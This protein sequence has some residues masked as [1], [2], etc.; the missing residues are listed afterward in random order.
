MTPRAYATPSWFAKKVGGFDRPVLAALVFS[1]LPLLPANRNHLAAEPPAPSQHCPGEVR[2]AV[3]GIGTSLDTSGGPLGLV[4]VLGAGLTTPIDRARLGTVNLLGGSGGPVGPLA[5]FAY[6]SAGEQGE[7]WH[8]MNTDQVSPIPDSLRQLVKDGTPVASTEPE[9]QAYWNTVARAGHTSVDAFRAAAITNWKQCSI[10][11]DRKTVRGEVFYLEGTLKNVT[12]RAVPPSGQ[13]ELVPDLYTAEMYDNAEP[14]NVSVIHFTDLPP[15]VRFEKGTAL[16]VSFA[17]YF[18]KLFPAGPK[19]KLVPLFIGRMVQPLFSTDDG[20]P[21]ATAALL[22]ACQAGPSE[23]TAALTALAL[24]RTNEH[25]DYW[26]LY[27]P[28]QLPA[29]R[30]DLLLQVHDRRFFPTIGGDD[31]E[32]GEV[33]AYY[34]FLVVAQRTPLEHF[35]KE[36]Q[37]SITYAQLFKNPANYRGEVIHIEGTLKRLSAYLAPRDLQRVGISTLYE[38]WIFDEMNGNNPYCVALTELPPGLHPASKM[39][40]QVKCD[41]FF[42]KRGD[43]EAPELPQGE[44]LRARCSSAAR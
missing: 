41:A 29:L 4:S 30:H 2:F 23:A 27:V 19:E 18:F 40:V 21:P 34:D 20:L 3:L 33:L 35:T 15:G 31:I 16:R 22:M 25:F 38:A 7:C 36:T 13:M 9:V 1:P 17:G 6:L 5:A 10:E 43:Y 11:K 8:L 32:F 44:R 26:K 42:F 28:R 39:T 12:R 24:L 14:P 37:T